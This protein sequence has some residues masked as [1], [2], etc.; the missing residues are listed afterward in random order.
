M[1]SRKRRAKMPK[2]APQKEKPE[3]SPS[4]L[5]VSSIEK[6]SSLHE[7]HNYG[8]PM[9]STALEE[10]LSHVVEHKEGAQAREGQR[11]PHQSGT[12]VAPKKAPR[13]GR[14]KAQTK[15]KS[16]QS[17]P[18]KAPVPG[19]TERKSQGLKDRPVKKRLKRAAEPVKVSQP[20]AVSTVSP[21][22]PSPTKKRRRP[23]L[24]SEDLT[25]NEDPNWNDGQ[26]RAKTRNS[27][28]EKVSNR[29]SPGNRLNN[30]KSSGE[31]KSLQDKK[32]KS[33]SGTSDTAGAVREVDLLQRVRNPSELDVV[34]DSFLEFTS[35]YSEGVGSKAV[36]QAIDALSHSVQEQLSERISAA[37]EL[38]CLRRD[39][40]KVASAINKK[41]ERLLEAKNEAIG[42]EKEV[43]G[44]QREKA[45]LQQRLEDL[46]KGSGLLSGLANLH[47]N[48]R[49]HADLD[50]PLQYG[51]SSLPALLLEA[52]RV[53]G[54]EEQ[55]RTLNGRLEQVLEKVT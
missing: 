44:L 36:C 23:S 31:R 7:H 2:V 14:G 6:D 33:S 20:Q 25:D 34:L 27:S 22:S 29:K 13:T 1:S 37:K 24:S 9:H 53:L 55:L 50:Q 4:Y 26:R 38:D 16:G 15:D 28:S 35:L 17:S 39:T 43:R 21:S 5:N 49:Q 19:R 30:R 47:R 12:V 3:S 42:K 48:Y 54:A 45:R 51:V 8:N 18:A 40:R 41:R 11:Q 46:R 52:Q 32:R 10:D